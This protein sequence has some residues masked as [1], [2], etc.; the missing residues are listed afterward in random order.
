MIGRIRRWW[1]DRLENSWRH[2]IKSG[3]DAGNEEQIQ[4]R[5]T[6]LAERILEYRNL[7]AEWQR[8]DEEIK[9]DACAL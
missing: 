2:C 4:H 8:S 6:E 5:L 7:Y 3:I 1:T 9:K